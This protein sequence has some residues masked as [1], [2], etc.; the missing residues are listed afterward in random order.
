MTSKEITKL[1]I[2]RKK[3]SQDELARLCGM[4]S[5]SNV[6]GILNRY[7]SMR[8]DTFE[9]MMDALGYEVIVRPK[10]GNGEEFKVHDVTST[11]VSSQP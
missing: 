3:I 2:K 4:K 8:V 9:Q 1:L 7:A 6:T 10:D 5:Q 11:P